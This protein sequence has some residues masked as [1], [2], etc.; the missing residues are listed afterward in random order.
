VWFILGIKQIF[1]YYLRISEFKGLAVG[2]QSFLLG[3]KGGESVKFAS[4]FHLMPK[5]RADLHEV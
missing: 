2:Y 3:N 1:R 4:H 5:V